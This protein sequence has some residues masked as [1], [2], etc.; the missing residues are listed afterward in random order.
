L[1][2]TIFKHRAAQIQFPRATGNYIKD[3]GRQGRLAQKQ[4]PLGRGEK[5][6]KKNAKKNAKK[7]NTKRTQKKRKKNARKTQKNARKTQ[8]KRKQKRQKFEV[9][10]DFPNFCFF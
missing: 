6:N 10:L 3:L 8:K 2:C 4:R 9:F 1:R 7:K 5:N